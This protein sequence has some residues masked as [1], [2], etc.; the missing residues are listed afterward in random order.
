MND[1]RRI[2]DFFSPQR[3]I[4]ICEGEFNP[5]AEKIAFNMMTMTRNSGADVNSLGLP[6]ETTGATAE[7]LKTVSEETSQ[8]VT[9]SFV[10]R[11]G[12]RRIDAGKS[13]Q[14]VKQE[15]GSLES[16]TSAIE[17]WATAKELR[18]GLESGSIDAGRVA[19]RVW[20]YG[21]ILYRG[22]GG[23]EIMKDNL[24]P[25][26]DRINFRITEELDKSIYQLLESSINL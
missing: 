9:V 12:I 6:E 4:D 13:P 23:T 18:W 10:G 22:G 3:I 7:S 5:L 21:T 25:V 14:D 8:G 19:F 26:A 24:Q 20:N 11:A 2:Q 16:F 15:F 17:K 1:A